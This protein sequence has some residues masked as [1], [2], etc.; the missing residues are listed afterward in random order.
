VNALPNTWLGYLYS[1]HF[2]NSAGYK[3]ARF[4]ASCIL[5]LAKKQGKSWDK[6]LPIIADM[7]VLLPIA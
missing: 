2:G 5:G 6:R 7:I 1:R 4:R 3:D